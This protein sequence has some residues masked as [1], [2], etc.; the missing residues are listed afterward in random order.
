M[1]INASGDNHDK[2]HE[3]LSLLEHAL[4]LLD[5]TDAPSQIGAYVDLGACHLRTALQ[6]GRPIGA[7][8]SLGEQGFAQD[9]PE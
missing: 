7:S 3:A 6:E 5:E 8:K 9:R 1:S 4:K 2:L